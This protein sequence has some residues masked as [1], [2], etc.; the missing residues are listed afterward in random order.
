MTC[1]C[2][3]RPVQHHKL[4]NSP[5]AANFLLSMLASFFAL[6]SSAAAPAPDFVLVQ[7]DTF[8]PASVAVVNVSVL[9]GAGGVEHSQQADGH[10]ALVRNA[11]SHFKA[12][13]PFGGTPCDKRVR[14]SVTAKAHDCRYATNASPF[15]MSSGACNCGVSVSNSTPYGEGAYGVGFGV[16]A[17]GQWVIGTLNETLVG[18]LNVSEFAV[19]FGWLVRDGANV[20]PAGNSVAPR[21]AVGTTSDGTLLSLVVDGCE[22]GAGCHFDFGATEQHMAQLLLQSGARYAVNLDGGGSS[23]VVV[24]GKVVNHPTDTDKWILKKER[25][26]TTILCVQ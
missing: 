22:Q 21:T 4:S 15:D 25:A 26:V 8:D 13:P 24:N 23:S 18:Q 20:A 11:P 5:R 12:P 16:T 7:P 1:F 10:L 3:G 19:G 14:T 9:A 17:Q 2:T 6:V